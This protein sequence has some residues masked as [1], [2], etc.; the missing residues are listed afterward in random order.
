[1]M[2][3]ICN[4]ALAEGRQKDAWNLVANQS[5]QLVNSGFGEILTLSQKLR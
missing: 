3:Q 1:M 4:L 5:S 2:E